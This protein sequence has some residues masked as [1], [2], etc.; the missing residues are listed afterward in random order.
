MSI[1]VYSIVSIRPSPVEICFPIFF[2]FLMLR[3]RGGK[4][5]SDTRQT[6][7]SHSR[8]KKKKKIKHLQ[9]LDA[10]YEINVQ[11]FIKEHICVCL[12]LKRYKWKEPFKGFRNCS[13]GFH[14]K[15]HLYLTENWLF[16]IMES[17]ESFYCNCMSCQKTH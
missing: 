6:S 11:G 9:N 10:L 13:F 2:I 17:E 8:W 3:M 1:S 7:F 4:V 12:N 14:K 15:S 16:W 5:L